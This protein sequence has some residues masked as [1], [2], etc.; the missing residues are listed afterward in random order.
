MESFVKI[1]TWTLYSKLLTT[2]SKSDKSNKKTNIKSKHLAIKMWYWS[3]YSHR[4][5]LPFVQW[6]L[7]A[8]ICLFFN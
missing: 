3:L 8:F 5:Y 7:C 2:I 4:L 6:V 1:N